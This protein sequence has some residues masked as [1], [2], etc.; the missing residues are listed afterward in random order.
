MGNQEGLEHVVQVRDHTE[1]V[2][3]DESAQLHVLNQ[4][5][6]RQE[7]NISDEK[8]KELEGD[9]TAEIPIALYGK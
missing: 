3:R 8:E 4:C 9:N 5:P 7:T 2:E 6:Q 1:V